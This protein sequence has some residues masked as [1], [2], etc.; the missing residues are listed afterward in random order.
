M[1]GKIISETGFDPVSCGLWAHHASAAPLWC[2]L[3]LPKIKLNLL[4]GGLSNGCDKA[5]GF[6]L[7]F[8][9][10][11]ATMASIPCILQQTLTPSR[12]VNSSPSAT[13]LCKLTSPFVGFTSTRSKARLG[14]CRPTRIGPCSNGSRTTCWLRFGK[15]GVDAEGAGI[16]GSQSRDDFDKEDV[17]QVLITLFGVFAPH[18]GFSDDYS[19]VKRTWWDKL[20]TRNSMYFSIP[21][22]GVAIVLALLR[23]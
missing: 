12:P 3:Y 8:L 5:V 13:T 9:E 6:E 18:I 21:W 22:W 17:E 20:L 1:K 7:W 15:N 2:C 11:K 16:Y 23:F 14:W 19:A 10:L 4:N